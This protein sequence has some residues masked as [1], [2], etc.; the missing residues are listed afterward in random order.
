MPPGAFTT[1]DAVRHGPQIAGSE[2]PKITTKGNPTAAAMWAGPESL[3][4]K[5]DAEASSRRTSSSGAPRSAFMTRKD[6]EKQNSQRLFDLL[7]RGGLRPRY[8]NRSKEIL[9][10]PRGGTARRPARILFYIDGQKMP[11]GAELNYL[12]A[13][14][15]EAVEVYASTATRPPEYN[16]TGYDCI[17]LLWLREDLR[18]PS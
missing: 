18:P 12:N 7:V 2:A 8:D 10:C 11:D 4:T 3:P 5:S 9:T 13:N 14:E 16:Q 1:S 6:I 15:I 17:A